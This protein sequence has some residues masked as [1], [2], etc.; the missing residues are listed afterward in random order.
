MESAAASS[1]VMSS[2]VVNSVGLPFECAI[3]IPIFLTPMSVVLCETVR[4]QWKVDPFSR[5]PGS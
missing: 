4:R 3:R 5:E 2:I 1:G